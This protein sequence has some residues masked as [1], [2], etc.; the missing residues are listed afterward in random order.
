MVWLSIPQ[1]FIHYSKNK[2][3]LKRSLNEITSPRLENDNDVIE[4]T[5]YVER[6]FRTVL[7]NLK[8]VIIEAGEDIPSDIPI[9]ETYAFNIGTQL[10]TKIEAYCGRIELSMDSASKLGEEGFRTVHKAKIKNQC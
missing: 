2:A 1:N 3:K 9:I 5:D 4:A 6:K 7:Q 8:K 10:W